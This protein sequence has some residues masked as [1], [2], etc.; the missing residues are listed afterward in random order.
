MLLCRSPY[1]ERELK[2]SKAIRTVQNHIS[3]PTEEVRIEIILR[4][5]KTL[6]ENEIAPHIGARIEIS[7]SYVIMPLR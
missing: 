7:I 3:L 1:G 5:M 6:L 2:L 4:I